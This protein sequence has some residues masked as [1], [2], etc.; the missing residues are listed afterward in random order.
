MK[1]EPDPVPDDGALEIDV[2]VQC[3]LWDDALPEAAALAQTAFRAA[4]Q[5]VGP[6]GEPQ[7]AEASI[8]LADD[9]FVQNLNREYRDRDTPTNVLSFPAS[10]PES[11]PETGKEMPPGMPVLL[12]DIVVAFETTA[13]EASQQ[14]KGLSD[15]LCH[16]VVH[17]MLHLLGYDHQTSTEADTME[18]LEIEILEGLRIPNPYGEADAAR[19]EDGSNP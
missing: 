7:A 15:H 18:A 10:G 6:V 2:S 8:V 11:G 4:F 5:A 12:G 1:A 19:I 13:A 17:G 14:G 16:L 3:P 9:A